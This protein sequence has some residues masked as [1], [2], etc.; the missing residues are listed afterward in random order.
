MTNWY[1]FWEGGKI[2]QGVCVLWLTTSFVQREKNTKVSKWGRSFTIEGFGKFGKVVLTR[3]VP[4]NAMVV[5]FEEGWSYFLVW[6]RLGKRKISCF[7]IAHRVWCTCFWKFMKALEGS[8]KDSARPVWKAGD[9]EWVY[10]NTR[11]MTQGSAVYSFIQTIFAREWQNW[12]GTR[13]IIKI[14]IR[15]GGNRTSY[16]RS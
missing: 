1:S 16:K 7:W 12:N 5:R 15:R 8:D 14:T 2:G 10:R 11:R 13:N 9:E 6:E 3:L 4:R